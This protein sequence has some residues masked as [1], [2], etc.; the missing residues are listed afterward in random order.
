MSRPPLPPF[1]D[2]TAAPKARLAEDG[3]NSR[4]PARVSLVYTPDTQWHNR[5]EFATGR[6]AIEALLTGTR[7]LHYR[8]IME[9]WARSA[10]RIAVRF[11]YEIRDDGGTWFRAY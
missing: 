10:N 6:A 8:L 3:W 7:E 11:A 9:V 2:E 1:A 4:D 5:A